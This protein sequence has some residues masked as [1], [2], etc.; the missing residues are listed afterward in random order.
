MYRT[1]D[2]LEGL[3]AKVS[4]LDPNLTPDLLI[5]R[6]RDADASRFRDALNSCRNVDTISKDVVTLDQDVSEID[7]DPE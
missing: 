6:R 3:L 4:E 5:S 2:V 7:T 1:G